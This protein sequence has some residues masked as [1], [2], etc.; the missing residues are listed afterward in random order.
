MQL[1]FASLVVQVSL[2][3]ILGSEVFKKNVTSYSNNEKFL[4]TLCNPKIH[5]GVPYSPPLFPILSKT[6]QFTI[7]Y[8]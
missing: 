6:I 2:S 3:H 7:Y 8:Q 4:H 5:F 1:K